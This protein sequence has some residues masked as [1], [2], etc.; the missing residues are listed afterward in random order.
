M[1]HKAAVDIFRTAGEDVELRVLKNVCSCMI[2][3]HVFDICLGKKYF[4]VIETLNIFLK[5]QLHQVFCRS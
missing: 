5:K 2:P 3:V 4:S 1:T